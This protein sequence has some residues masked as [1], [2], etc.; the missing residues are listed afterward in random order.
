MHNKR[1]VLFYYVVHI[2]QD[3]LYVVRYIITKHEHYA[4][5]ATNTS[6]DQ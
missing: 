6:I 5:P 1:Y 4:N 2:V 3:V